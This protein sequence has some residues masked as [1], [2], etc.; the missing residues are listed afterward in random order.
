M[1]PPNIDQYGINDGQ[2]A[3]QYYILMNPVALSL[4]LSCSVVDVCVGCDRSSS[5]K[6]DVRLLFG[7]LLLIVGQKVA[8]GARADLMRGK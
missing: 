3:L 8:R 2:V 5:Q 4:F 7:L 6:G 1:L